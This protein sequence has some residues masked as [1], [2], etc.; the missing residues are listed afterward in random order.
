MEL[1]ESWTI[2]SEVL[3][4]FMPVLE[5][6]AITT[7]PLHNNASSAEEV[8]LEKVENINSASLLHCTAARPHIDYMSDQ[9]TALLIVKSNDHVVCSRDL[10]CAEDLADDEYALLQEEWDRAADDAPDQETILRAGDIILL[11]VHRLH[12][13][14]MDTCNVVDFPWHEDCETARRL[15][16]ENRLVAVHL[17]FEKRP[18]R[19]E[20][21]EAF[22]AILMISRL[23]LSQDQD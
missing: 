13:L 7:R 3:R 5:D 21:E 12:W 9:W 20:V 16:E 17:E 8:F 18:S 11:D 2:E 1:Q 4:D 22:I 6:A 19:E 10:T 15:A 14:D 23:R